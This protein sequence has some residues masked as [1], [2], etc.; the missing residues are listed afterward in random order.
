LK[1]DVSV[2]HDRRV[3]RPARRHAP[4]FVQPMAAE[5]V[6]RLPEGDDWMYE[7][8]FDGYRALLIKNGPRVQLRSRNNKDLT[9]DV[10]GH[11]RG[12]SPLERAF[13]RHRRRDRSD[14][15]MVSK[16]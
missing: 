9:P 11:P 8:K 10:S 2:G 5:V 3:V 6:E 4:A 14:R 16:R 15:L 7:V 1:K 13:C 12:R